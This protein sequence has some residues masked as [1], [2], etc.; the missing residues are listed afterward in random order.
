[1][2]LGHSCYTAAT[3]WWGHDS[4]ESPRH[5]GSGKSRLTLSCPGQVPL[6]PAFCHQ[7]GKALGR[8]GGAQ[9]LWVRATGDHCLARGC[10]SGEQ[11]RS[12]PQGSHPRPPWVRGAAH[13]ALLGLQEKP[14]NTSLLVS[15]RGRG[16]GA[17]VAQ[18][19]GCPLPYPSAALETGPPGPYSTWVA[20]PALLPYKP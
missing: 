9:G 12:E 19:L 6:R 15:A 8:P 7:P 11:S 13:S 3:G 4:S 14:V 17:D 5:R 20:T 10:S 2:W 18:G 1:M 16:V